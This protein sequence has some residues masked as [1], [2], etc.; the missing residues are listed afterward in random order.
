VRF[1]A[2][3]GRGEFERSPGK[4]S[5]RRLFVQHASG[6]ATR[7]RPG[8]SRLPPPGGHRAHRLPWPGAAAAVTV[9]GS[10]YRSRPAEIQHRGTGRPGTAEAPGDRP[11]RASRIRVTSYTGSVLGESRNAAHRGQPRGATGRTA[12]EARHH[13]VARGNDRRTRPE[14]SRSS[15]LAAATR[16]RVPPYRRVTRPRRGTFGQ[17]VAAASSGLTPNHFGQVCRSPAAG[18]RGPSDGGI[19]PAS[20]SSICACTVVR[21]T[22]IRGAPGIRSV[23]QS[24]GKVV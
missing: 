9:S 20:Q 22:Q 15:S 1:G 16:C 5:G 11:G 13:P 18:S 7:R 8:A 6:G 10:S 3:R 4:K 17:R 23:A 19:C 21:L 2:E 24:C 12:P 14:W